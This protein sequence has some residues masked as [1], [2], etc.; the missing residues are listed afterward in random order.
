MIPIRFRTYPIGKKHSSEQMWPVSIAQ[1]IHNYQIW[2]KKRRPNDRKRWFNLFEFFRFPIE[3]MKG[4][5]GGA[6]L[7]ML[8]IKKHYGNILS[9]LYLDYLVLDTAGSMG[10]CFNINVFK[11]SYLYF[12][13][14]RDIS[15]SIR[16]ISTC[17][18]IEISLY[19]F[20]KIYLFLNK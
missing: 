7:N 15:I 10:I 2:S 13:M 9:Y 14:N 16:E 17:K 19:F 20:I 4:M 6:R 11:K 18:E 1:Y 12:W 8:S 5:T 3:T